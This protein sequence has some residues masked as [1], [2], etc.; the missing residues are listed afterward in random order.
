[1]RLLR[2]IWEIL[3]EIGDET[4][5]DRYLGSR[6]LQPSR[7]NWRVFSEQRMSAKYR[8]PKCC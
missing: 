6:G 8:Q 3:R 4:A 2:V 5:Y 1:M 7:E